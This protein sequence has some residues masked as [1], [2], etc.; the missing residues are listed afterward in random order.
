MGG[1]EE[2]FI[3]KGDKL[4]YFE[5]E[6]EETNGS[7]F[8]YYR[9]MYMPDM[10]KPTEEFVRFNYD[11]E[12]GPHIHLKKRDEEVKEY[13]S[14]EF[15]VEKAKGILV[16]IKGKVNEIESLEGVLLKLLEKKK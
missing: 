16:K 4:D 3:R 12:K 11:L 6:K 14:P 13:E 1:I 9:I 7:K 5:L 10:E 15:D 2:N 8:H